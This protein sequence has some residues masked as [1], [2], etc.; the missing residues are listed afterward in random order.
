MTAP[1]EQARDDLRPPPGPGPH[2]E[3]DALLAVSRVLAG[4]LDQPRV[5]GSALHVV[6]GLMGAE[7]ES[8]LLIDPD[9]GALHFYV[10]EGPAGEHIRGL[11]LPPDAGIC[12]Y[13]ARTGQPLIVN[14]AQNDPRQY[15]AVDAT[16]GMTTRN[17]LCVPIRSTQRMWGVLEVINKRTP[18]GFDAADLRLAEVLAAQI[19]LALENAHLHDEIV[20][21]ERMAAVGQTVSGLA[22]CIKNILNGIRSG[23]SVIDRAMGGNDFP[24]VREGWRVVRR[25][26]DMLGHLVLDMLALARDAKPRPFPTDVNDLAR[27][28]CR[29]VADRAAERDIAV[30]CVECPGLDEV[31]LDATHF[32]RCLLNLVSNAIEA[33]GPGGRVRIRLVRGAGRDRFTVSVADDG[34]GIAPETAAR[35]FKEFFTTKGG[36]GTGLGL[37]VTRKLIREMG[38][39][40]R[41]HSVPGRGTRFV[42]WLPLRP[43]E[44]PP[45]GEPS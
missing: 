22:H 26:N 40:I 12:G 24:T 43:P 21:R 20:A 14:D 28:V 2:G 41:F 4:K 8:I 42:F 27:Q 36:R 30:A 23:S 33:C 32:Y 38:G 31:E 39:D 45:T 7:A 37:P 1:S 13:V 15:N 16:T 19:G 44:Q 35:L 34:E 6:G 29:L 18:G 5:L 3:L 17:V 25:N 11:P 10:A 9:S